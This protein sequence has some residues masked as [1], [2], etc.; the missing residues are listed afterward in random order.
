MV[1]VLTGSGC[2]HADERSDRR[3]VDLTYRPGHQALSGHQ[4]VIETLQAPV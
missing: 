3:R 2:L 1:G 4:V